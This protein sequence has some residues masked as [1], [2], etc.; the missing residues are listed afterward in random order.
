MNIKDS[1]LQLQIEFECF[2]SGMNTVLCHIHF[3]R[4]FVLM[5]SYHPQLV[6]I[7]FRLISDAFTYVVVF[8]VMT[9]FV[10]TWFFSQN[11]APTNSQV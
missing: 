3:S 7:V 10:S 8:W 6:I 2:W 1:L 5:F 4:L 11:F 9:V